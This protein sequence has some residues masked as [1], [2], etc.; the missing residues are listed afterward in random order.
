MVF[1]FARNPVL[2]DDI[3]TLDGKTYTAVRDASL[4]PNGL[5]FVTGSGGSMKGVTVPYTN[6][7]DEVKAKYHYNPYTFALAFARQNRVVYLTKSAA[8]SLDQLDAARKKAQR[9]KKLLGF[10]ME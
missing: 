3:T 8:F 4:K 7:T 2:A 6:L 9:E 5:F 10:I 1:G